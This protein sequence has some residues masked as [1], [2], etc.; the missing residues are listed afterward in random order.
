MTAALARIAVRYLERAD[1]GVAPEVRALL[2]QLEAFAA[3]TRDGALTGSSSG[4]CFEPESEVP[5]IDLKVAGS[6]MTVRDVACLLGVSD[7]AVTARCRS[8]SLTAVRARGGWEID[9]RS[10]TALASAIQRK[11]DRATKPQAQRPA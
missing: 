5:D 1:G 11:D 3:E 4:R 8:G 9:R 10:A 7:Q 6:P 2:R